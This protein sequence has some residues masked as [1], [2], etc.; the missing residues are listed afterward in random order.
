MRWSLKYQKTY[1][2]PEERE[3][4]FSLFYASYMNMNQ[5]Q[6]TLRTYTMGLTK[7]SD[8]TEEEFLAKYTGLKVSEP[9]SL[10]RNTESIQE[11]D[12]T[13]SQTRGGQD[14]DWRQQGAVAP[15]KDQGQCG[16]CWAFAASSAIESAWKISGNKLVILSEQQLVDCSAPQGNHGCNGGTVEAAFKY[17]IDTRGMMQASDYPYSA[18]EGKCKF[19]QSKAVAQ[20]SSYK[21]IPDNNCGALEAAVTKQPVGAG[22]AA[23]AL[24]YYTGGVFS[25]DKCGVCVNHA[26]TVVGFGFDESV[27][28]NFWI[29]RNSWGTDWGEQ[30]YFRLDKDN[31]KPYG[32][33]G[34]CSKV[35]YPQV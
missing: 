12:N 4:R 22:V 16:S 8:L 19:Q 34:V 3:Y 25:S 24:M 35:S 6:G 17:V 29:V 20:I 9:T 31:G 21:T 32:M 2:T 10:L 23:N 14:V 1:K 5:L 26:V 13:Q 30:G 28:K 15:I 33:C 7:F 18:T 27:N 11:S